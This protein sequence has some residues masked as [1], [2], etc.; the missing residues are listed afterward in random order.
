LNGCVEIACLDEQE[1]D[2]LL[3]APSNRAVGEGYLAVHNPH[4]ECGI[5]LQVLDINQV[6]AMAQILL[7]DLA[8]LLKGSALTGRHGFPPFLIPIRQK[9][10][11]HYLRLYG[12]D[13]LAALLA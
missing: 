12:I 2:E 5:V 7:A 8:C 6:K 4:R 1:L 13:V 11:L 10:V 3:L 9:D